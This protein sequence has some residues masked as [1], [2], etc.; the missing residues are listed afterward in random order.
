MT[1]GRSGAA[2]RGA[3]PRSATDFVAWPKTPRYYRDIVITEKI[4]G[5][6]ACAV[7]EE[8][9]FGTHVQ[10][11]PDTACALILGPNKMGNGGMPAHEYVVS[12][13]SR[14]RF[15]KPESD[16]HGFARWVR[17]NAYNLVHDLEAG[18]HYGEW[19]GSGINRGY[20]LTKGEKRFSL[21]NT[22]KWGSAEFATPGLG[23]VPVLY[24]GDHTGSAI[25]SALG[26]LMHDGSAAAPGY[27]NPE[28]VCIYHT[29]SG[30]VF[31]VTLDG[32]EAKGQAA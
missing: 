19:W 8:W 21:F 6:N 9:P 3:D 28:G 15:V 5:T 10:G 25:A 30:Q 20:G 7:I 17:D 26:G 22:K 12:A 31:K 11:I 1:D 29:A 23:V 24:E 16:T 32:D 2:T 27:D 18:R 4:D 14:T 13:Q